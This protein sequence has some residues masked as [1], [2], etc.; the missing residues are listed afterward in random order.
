MFASGPMLA[1]RQ[2][3]RVGETPWSCP[4]GK[5][6]YTKP[7]GREQHSAIPVEPRAP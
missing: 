5:G 2:P 6:Q 7:D 3:E 1:N 4:V